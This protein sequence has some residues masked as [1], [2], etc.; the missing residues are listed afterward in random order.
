[1]TKPKNG[2]AS[3]K[4]TAAK[5][6]AAKPAVSEV[7]AGDQPAIVEKDV[8]VLETIDKY[9]KEKGYSPTLRELSVMV[10]ESVSMVSIRVRKLAASG[11]VHVEP[12]IARSVRVC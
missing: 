12:R 3:K 2:S 8:A 10:G 11:K 6:E 5:K 1:M 7:S 9:C 4:K